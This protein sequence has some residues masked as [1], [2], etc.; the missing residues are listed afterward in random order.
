MKNPKLI[1]NLVNSLNGL[2]LLVYL[3]KIMNWFAFL[4]PVK[5][6]HI[7]IGALAVYGLRS[8]LEVKYNIKNPIK[9]NQI[10]KTI[11]YIGAGLF[12][13]GFL[14]KIMHWPFSN[15]LLIL[16]VLILVSSFIVSFFF[17]A[18]EDVEGANSEI[19]DDI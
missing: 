4:I 5:L 15:F 8:W 12:V 7:F 11:Y 10:T 13:L 2:L 16:G 17:V 14:F 19:L 6:P 18:D 1:W 9:S 3:S